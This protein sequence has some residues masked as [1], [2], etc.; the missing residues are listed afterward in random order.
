MKEAK[1][2]LFF[3]CLYAMQGTLQ[4]L[5]PREQEE[6][7]VLLREAVADT[8]PLPM[9]L[10]ASGKQRLLLKLAGK[11]MEATARVLNF[12]IKIHVLT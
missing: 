7:K 5:N 2:N 10:A 12:L 3:S 9:E 6:A 11:N 8:Q 1:L 4:Y